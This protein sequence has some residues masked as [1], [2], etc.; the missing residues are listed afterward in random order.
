MNGTTREWRQKSSNTNGW[1]K[2]NEFKGSLP[3]LVLFLLP[4]AAARF[5]DTN[6]F[7]LRAQ[8]MHVYEFTSHIGCRMFL[9]SPVNENVYGI[10]KITDY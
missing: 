4:A 6:Y 3:L 7:I 10:N 5:Y 2:K 9:S 8:C 1:M